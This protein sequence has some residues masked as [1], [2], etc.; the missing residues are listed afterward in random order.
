MGD[1]IEIR[2]IKEAFGPIKKPC[3][4]GSI[5]SNLGHLEAAAGLAG[6]LKA[7][8][9]LKNKELPATAQFTELNPNINLKNTPLYIVDRQE[10]WKSEGPR[11]CGV[12]S[13]GS[14]GSYA[15]VVLQEYTRSQVLA[16]AK[17]QPPVFTFSAKTHER[18]Q[19][20]VQTLLSFLTDQKKNTIS[21]DSL[22]YT[23]QRREAM[24]YRLAF[25]ADSLEEVIEKLSAFIHENEGIEGTFQGSVKEGEAVVKLID[26]VIGDLIQQSLNSRK[27]DKIAQLWVSGVA[28]PWIDFYESRPDLLT[29]PHY[30]FSRERYWFDKTTADVNVQQGMSQLH[31]LLQENTSNFQECSFTSTFTGNEFFLKDHV[32]NNQKTLPGV[33]YLEMAYT[34]VSK[35][36]DVADG[37]IQLKNVVWARPIIVGDSSQTVHISL[38]PQDNGQISYEVYTEEGDT[39]LPHSQGVALVSDSPHAAPLDL[40]FIQARINE[41]TL[42]PDEIYKAFE[43]MGIYYGPSHRGIESL[44]LGKDEILAKL[45][46][47]S[48]VANT[49]DQFTLHPSLMDAAVQASIGFLF[50]NG[51]LPSKPFL[52]FA[53]DSIEVFGPC[54]TPLWVWI[55]SSHEGVVQKLDI[56]LMDERGNVLVTMRGFSSR[57]LDASELEYASKILAFVTDNERIDLADLAYTLQVGREAMDERFGMLVNSRDELIDKLT[58]FVKG[59]EGIDNLFLEQVKRNKDFVADIESSGEFHEIVDKCIENKR[60]AKILNF[61]V[62]GL[63]IDWNKLYADQKP[64]RISLPTYPFAKERNWIE[65]NT[66]K[67]DALPLALTQKPIYIDSGLETPISDWEISFVSDENTLASPGSLEKRLEKATQLMKVLLAEELHIAAEEIQENVGYFSMGITSANLSMLHNKLQDYIDKD[68]NIVELF[69]FPNVKQFSDYVASKYGGN[70]DRLII[71]KLRKSEDVSQKNFLQ[72]IRIVSL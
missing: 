67:A 38:V 60:F 20:Y 4:I 13:F 41:K 28:I 22:A 1:P 70:L 48:S 57:V 6:V 69:N 72:K 49:K 25:S 53:L 30:P 17:Y 23:L 52:P 14:G 42:T 32:I 56:D 29:L 37:V 8:V 68:I 34:A 9:S 26:P 62:K 58:R 40:P 10:A 31:P 54:V 12:S 59:E 50:A 47:P 46:L 63:H 7:I 64:N 18:L 3:G 55:R 65:V 35:V 24:D 21:L 19:A 16:K 27:M 66:G 39:L 43:K 5:K 51:S 61:W 36:C 71:S 33:A 45:V 44:A 11:L 15:H 2:G